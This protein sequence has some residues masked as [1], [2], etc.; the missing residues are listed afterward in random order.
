MKRGCCGCNAVHRRRP[1][2]TAVH[3]RTPPCF[4][5]VPLVQQ[6]Y[7]GHISAILGKNLR[8]IKRV[9]CGSTI[10]LA[11]EVHYRPGRKIGVWLV[12]RPSVGG[13]TPGGPPEA[14]FLPSMRQ[15]TQNVRTRRNQHE[16]SQN[17]NRL[18]RNRNRPVSFFRLRRNRK[19]TPPKKTPVAKTTRTKTVKKG[20][21]RG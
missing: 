21:S 14:V 2:Q 18:R 19:Q 7:C 1:P 5:F 11:Y 4:M 15:Y 16:K 6:Q 12:V 10:S 20:A 9:A 8:Q 17:Q 3:R 13:R